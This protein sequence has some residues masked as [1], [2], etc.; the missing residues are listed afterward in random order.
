M[1]A[2]ALPSATIAALRSGTCFCC[3]AMVLRVFFLFIV[4][5]AWRRFIFFG[6]VC[7]LVCV[8]CI[9]KFNITTVRRRLVFLPSLSICS[10][11]ILHAFL[12]VLF[13]LRSV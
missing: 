1:G 8:V 13:F 5:V 3:F 11:R 9:I 6:A 4:G 7:T 12:P 10:F 2:G